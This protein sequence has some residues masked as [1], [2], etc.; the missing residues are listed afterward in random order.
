MA[1]K[2]DT[3]VKRMRVSD[4]D[5]NDVIEQLDVV[6]AKSA[7]TC[8]DEKRVDARMSFQD[9]AILFYQPCGDQY[10]TEHVMVK[11]RNIST[12]GI[13]F[14]FDKLLMP[15]TQ[16]TLTLVSSERKGIRRRCTI[17]RCRALKEV[18]IFELGSRFDRPIDLDEVFFMS[19]VASD[20]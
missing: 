20:R 17:V 5:L 1:R 12:T 13:A 8:K 6:S 18:G 9:D 15:G 14:L 16:C 3:H 2:A 19:A 4:D 11:C 7:A 10:G